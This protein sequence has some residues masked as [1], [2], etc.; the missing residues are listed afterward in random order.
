M[1]EGAMSIGTAAKAPVPEHVRPESVVDFDIYGDHRFLEAGDM[2]VGVWKL[3]Q[4]KG[5]GIFWTPRNGGH[6]LVNDFELLFEA[7]RQP[8][9][10]SSQGLTVPPMPEEPQLIPLGLDPPVHGDFRLPLV[11]FFSPQIVRGMEADIRR[12][13]GELIEGIKPA[14]RCEFVRAVAVP[15]PVTIFMKLMGM[16]PERLD[17]YRE[18]V[19]DMGSNNDDRR[20]D[21]YVKI[22]GLMADL[23]RERQRE[24]RDDLISRLIDADVGGRAPTFDELQAYCMLLFAAGLDTVANSLSFGVN[25]LAGAPEMQDRLR[26]NPERIPDAVEEFLRRFAIVNNPRTIARDAQFGGWRSGR[27]S[28]WS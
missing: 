6:W 11:K 27:A 19:L 17:E 12:L 1:R 21:S 23:I 14:G 15:L 7:V 10:F 8:D 18:W 16:P 20:A 5:N 2:H 9:L 22:H 3:A 25:Y 13:A 28:A 26:A 24:R 4:E